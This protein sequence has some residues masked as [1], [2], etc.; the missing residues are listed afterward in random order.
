MCQLIYWRIFPLDYICIV[1][2]LKAFLCNIL[3]NRTIFLLLLNACLTMF[4]SF[5]PLWFLKKIVDKPKRNYRCLFI[6]LSH[7]Q[8]ILMYCSHCS[9]HAQCNFQNWYFLVQ[10]VPY[11]MKYV[12]CLNKVLWLV[13]LRNINILLCL[14]TLSVV[15]N[16]AI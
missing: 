14:C 7:Q 11:D 10:V 5:I 13:K 2:N 6:A 12:V 1:S 4:Y 9:T 16:C 3:V 15:T 8:I